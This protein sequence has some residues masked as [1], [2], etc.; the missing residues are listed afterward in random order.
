MPA[1][2]SNPIGGRFANGTQLAMLVAL[3]TQSRSAWLVGMARP[4]VG[5]KLTSGI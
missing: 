2:L 1:D 5:L 3:F 4:P